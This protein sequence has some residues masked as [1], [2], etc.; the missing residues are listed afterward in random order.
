MVIPLFMTGIMGLVFGPSTKNQMPGIKVLVADNDQGI[1]AQFLLAAFES[2]QMK[3][4]FQISYVNESE[5]FNIIEDGQASALIIIPSQFSRRVLKG[6]EI[7]LQIIKNP[8]EQ[9]LPT[10]VEDFMRTYAVVISGFMQI[11]ND[12][13]SAINLSDKSFSG[14]SKI[15]DIGTLLATGTISGFDKI[16][17]YLKP[18]MI[19]LKT[20]VEKTKKQAASFNLFT[21]IFPGISIMCLLFI[22][23]I[24]LRE[25]LS[26]REDGKLQRIMFSPIRTRELILGRIFSGW[27]MGILVYVIMVV[28]GI[29]IFDINWGNYLY[30]FIF[31]SI[32]C[33]WIASFF[34]LL[35]SF[36]KNKNQA[37]SFTA[38]I[39]LVFSAFGGSMVP[40]NQLPDVLNL[41]SSLTINYWFI[42]GITLITEG[43]FPLIP[44]VVVSASGYLLFIIAV[45]S[46]KNR[47]VA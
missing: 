15:A 37:G 17:A 41:A 5:G 33:F 30:V 34:A 26:E 27:M 11:F 2:P 35:N 7:Q 28:F 24:F 10:I 29:L 43:S 13:L 3:K 12:Q 16:Q 20:E 36:F 8:S 31:V 4:M 47:I 23:E 46:L 6:E 22:I 1:G 44:F 42:K 18:L 32:T 45:K 40:L 19:D 38:P 39:I 25:I 9:F 14:G 21:Y